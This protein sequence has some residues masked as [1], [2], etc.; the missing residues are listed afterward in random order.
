[1]KKSVSSIFALSLAFAIPNPALA[2][3]KDVAIGAAIGAVINQGINNSKN[4]KAAPAQKKKTYSNAAPSL[5]SQFNLSERMQ[6]QTSLNGMGL[7]VGGVDGALGPKSRRAISQFQASRGQAQTGQL[8]REQFVAL[9]G[10]GFAT[11]NTLMPDRRLVQ[12]EVVML[13]Q[14]LQGAGFYN[15]PIDGVD[16]AG[17][18]NARVGFL[19]SQNRNPAQTTQVQ[20][21]VLAASA[22]GFQAPQYLVQE[23]QT[24]MAAANNATGFGFAP[25]QQQLNGQFGAVP[26][27]TPGFGA[28]PQGNAGFGQQALQPQQNN[29]F[30]A[31]APQQAAGFGAQAPQQNNGFG[32]QA[33]QQ[34]NGFGAQAPVTASQNTPLFGAAPQQ[35]MQPAP[36]QQLQAAPQQQQQPLF[37]QNQQPQQQLQPAQQGQALFASTGTAA[38]QPQQQQLVTTAPQQ[39]QPQSSLDVFSIP[40]AQQQQAATTGQPVPAAPAPSTG[41]FPMTPQTAQAGQQPQ[42]TGTFSTF[43]STN[44]N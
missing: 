13:Q 32:A 10:I 23:A 5:N 2:D 28:Q 19:V 40:N 26:V 6:I 29:G 11:A 20:S 34:N 22:A 27:T 18:Q 39:Q 16:G 17:T 31:Q 35:Q 15:G 12:N 37:P 30:G 1:M 8:T 38:G 21:L 33:P 41:L 42:P 25:Q 9:T 44:G 7:N 24:Q 4:K 3:L 43:G 14:S 36:Q